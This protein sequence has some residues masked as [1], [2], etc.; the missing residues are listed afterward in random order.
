MPKNVVVTKQ[1]RSDLVHASAGEIALPVII[2]MAFG[3]G[4]IDDS[5]G[6]VAPTEDMTALRS[7]IYRKEIDGY[8]FPTD[9]TCRYTCTL[10]TDEC[11]G[12]YISEVGLYD[13]NGNIACIKA[14]IPKGKDDDMEMTFTVDD[15]F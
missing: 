8:E 12:Q 15:I 1:R 10:A 6:I 4:G 3:K 2:G 13:A 5:G 9:T 14:F 7:E 11:A